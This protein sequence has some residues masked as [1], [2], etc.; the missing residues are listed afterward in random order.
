MSTQAR[1]TVAPVR[2]LAAV[3]AA[4]RVL[5]AAAAPSFF[6]SWTW[7]GCRAAARFPDPWL[8]RAERGG[9]VVGLALL[10]RRDGGLW[11]NENGDAALD[12]PYVEHNGV[13]LARD[14]TDLLP[15]CLAAL[16]GAARRLRLSG[17]DAAHLAAARAAGAVRLR[18]AHVAPYVDLT[19][20]ANGPDAWLATRS[21]NTR[22]QLRRSDRGFGAITVRRAAT[23]AEASAFL[24]A[25][26]RLHQATWTARGRPGAFANPEFLRFHRDLLARAVPR[27]EAELLRIDGTCATVG[28]LYNFVFGA[29]VHT[30]QSGFDYAAAGKHGKPGLTCHHAAILRAAADGAAV[31]DFLAGTDRTKLSLATGTQPLYW[32]DAAA[33][34]SASGIALR[35]AD[36]A[37]TLRNTASWPRLVSS[38]PKRS[39]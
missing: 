31:Y 26:A 16:L 17:V 36:W 28:Y 18:R 37:S 12:A 22:Q 5:E 34:W 3:A 20:L 8:L 4:W 35:L 11:L 23:L 39:A 14:A 38:Q 7:V 15:A 19:M 6:Q 13:L 10:N 1:I 21:A 30:Y 32:L 2:H 9:R 24:E 27:G 25:L 33:A 29:R